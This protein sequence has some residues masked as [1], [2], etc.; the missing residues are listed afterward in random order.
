VA[1]GTVAATSVSVVSSTTITAVSPA[2]TSAN[3]VDVTVTAPGSGT[4]LPS[5]AD[6]FTYTAPALVAQA[7]LTLTSTKG[8]AGTALT[9][10]SSG[11]SGSGAVT[12]SVTSTGTAECSISGTTLNAKSAGTCSVSVSK[13][14]DATYLAASSAATTVTFAAKVVPVQVKATKVNGTVLVGRISIV[15]V[16]GSGFYNKPTITSN[17]PHTSAV[18]IHDRGTQLVVRV[19]ALTGSTTGW[20]VFTITLAN[21]K[22]AKVRYL[23]KGGLTATVV[24]GTV[25]VGRISTVTINGVGFYNK[26]NI[27]SNDPHTSADVIHD[28][29]TQLVVL[30][31]A[32]PG[33]ATGWHVFTITLE[34]GQSCTVKYLVK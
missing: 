22:S 29:G 7:P 6:H 21:G 3:T 17:D 32:H 34:N 13:A 25:V 2:S 19:R 9:L 27:T 33:S 16:I 30:V 20:H 31:T 24:N 10:T 28:H 5:A 14:A 26:P 8:T 18:V 1:F 11:G 23:V 4:S 12:Y 15:T